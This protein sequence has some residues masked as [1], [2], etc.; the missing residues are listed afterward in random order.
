VVGGSLGDRPGLGRGVIS[1]LHQAVAMS[2]PPGGGPG[3]LDNVIETDAAMG[4]SNTGGPL[5]DVSGRVVGLAVGSPDGLGLAIAT[6]GIQPEV[7]QIIQN[8]QLVLPALGVTTVTVTADQ[9]AV[10]GGI[11]GARVT[12][13]DGAGVA[14]RAGLKVGDVITQLDDEKLDDAHPLLQVLASRFQPGQKVTVS[15]NRTGNGGQIQLAL[16]T[17]AGRCQ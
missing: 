12:A 10:A 1:A 9:A 13:L 11:A 4:A 14:E 16:G 2:P 6:A 8:G 15:Y 7:Q 3:Q 17:Q 5:L